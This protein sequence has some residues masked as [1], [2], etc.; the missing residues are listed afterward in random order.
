MKQFISGR[1]WKAVLATILTLVFAVA[2]V[3]SLTLSFAEGYDQ[4]ASKSDMTTVEEVGVEGMEPIAL[5]N[6]DDGTYRVTVECSSSMF[7]I[8][9]A[10]LTV[11][12]GKGTLT[13]TMKSTTYPYL[14]A[15]TSKEAAALNDPAKYIAHEENADGKYTFTMPLRAL[16]ESFPCAAFSSNKEMWYDRNLLVRADSLPQD[17]VNVK[18]PDYEELEKAAQ[19]KRIAAMQKEQ[20]EKLAAI[21]APVDLHDG[22]YT[23]EVDMTGG[24]GRASITS[25]TTLTVIDGKAYA[26]VLWSSPNY[27]YMIVGGEKIEPRNVKEGS[28]SS[29]LIP[30]EKFDEPFKVIGDTTAMSTPHE[31]EYELTFHQ[32]T[33]KKYSTKS[34]LLMIASL[35]IV[36][37]GVFCFYWF[38]HTDFGRKKR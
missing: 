35:L 14:F 20:E 8:E 19:D 18:L 17:A 9:Q 36:L 25:P 4:V 6:V 34:W 38:W 23:I 5:S 27:D 32:D 28:N 2:T 24:T 16:D 33:V 3:S 26:T 7:K 31:I 11:K 15:G 21:A 30:I 1:G 37:A 13:L 22:S 29:F 12:E 10:D